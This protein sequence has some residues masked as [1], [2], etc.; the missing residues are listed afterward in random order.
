MEEGS[1]A[2]MQEGKRQE[3]MGLGIGGGGG[4]GG[5]WGA[6]VSQETHPKVDHQPKVGSTRYRIIIKF[7][8]A[9]LEIKNVLLLLMIIVTMSHSSSQKRHLQVAGLEL[10]CI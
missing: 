9:V 7:T 2:K 10:K 4:W 3:V 6:V 8:N 1:G 5:R